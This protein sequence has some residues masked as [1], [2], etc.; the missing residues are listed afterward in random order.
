MFIQTELT[1]NP[2]VVK[3]LPG[4][5]VLPAS[6]GGN[7]GT[8]EFCTRTEAENISDLAY[9]L[10]G[11]EGVASVFF[12]ADFVSVAK[13]AEADWDV[14]RPPILG[15]IMEHCMSGRPFV[16]EG[17]KTRSAG[18]GDAEAD[19]S[20]EDAPVVARIKALLDERV[21]PAVAQD[22]GD[23]VFHGFEKGIVYLTL[24]GACAGCPSATMT[25]KMGV[26][27]LLRHYIPEV[28]EVRAR[29]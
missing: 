6:E 10:F 7:A 18:D 26:E 28:S 23:I 3:F 20:E 27:N 17:V 14:L 24:R 4:V 5:A 19:I 21:R 16:R 2:A 13:L 29:A 22:G 11:I 25:L 8:A 12:G 1:P 15:L 9:A